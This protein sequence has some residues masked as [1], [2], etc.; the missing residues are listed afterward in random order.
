[1]NNCEDI[2]TPWEKALLRT[3][4]PLLYTYPCKSV[5]FFRMIVGEYDQRTVYKRYNVVGNGTD[6]VHKKSGA[7][8]SI[9]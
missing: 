4:L 2:P 9:N 1:M 7:I 3:L 5:Q 6:S 8:Y